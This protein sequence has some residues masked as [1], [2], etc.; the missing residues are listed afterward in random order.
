MPPAIRTE[1]RGCLD[2]FGATNLN[3]GMSLLHRRRFLRTSLAFAAAAPLHAQDRKPGAAPAAK[4][5]LPPKDPYADAVL[6]K[7]EP[8][9]PAEGAFTLVALPDTQHYSE[10][11]PQT[12]LAQTRWIAEQRDK[13]RIAGVLHLGDITNQNT[14]E[15][16]KNAV[17]AMKQLDG[18]VPCF[19]A[20][21]NHDY[22]P[23]GNGADRTTLFS[24]HFPAAA[25]KAAPTFGGFYDREPER[26]ENSFHLF[27]A[28]G[29]KL[30]ALCL[31][32]GPRRDVV[33]WADEVAAKHRDRGI[34]LVTHAFIYDNDTRYDF[35]KYGTK[36]SWNPHV[37]GMAKASGDDVTDGEELWRELICKH[38]NF[39]F[40][41]NGHVL[42][43]GL[44]RVTGRTPDGRR[45]P[46]MLVNFQM[47]PNGG[48]GWLRLL[49]V[50]TDGSMHV[51]DYSPVRGERNESAQNKFK[52]MLAAP[53]PV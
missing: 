27:E 51:C 23:R 48:D 15:Q 21:G 37:Y 3:A 32:F 45:I 33:R 9:P 14:P 1:A 29:R 47:R 5:K 46:Q 44:G 2:I 34:I 31:E 36:Q 25:L 49:E 18:Q 7:G 16:W 19:M 38:G 22:G 13:R 42:H 39:L 6:V 35:K 20:P 17:A 52:T 4:K 28:G 30:L 53:A 11:Y 12:F 43:D 41:I 10:K 24:E 8:A 26:V 40:T 50:R